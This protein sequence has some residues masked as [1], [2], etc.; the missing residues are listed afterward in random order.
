MIFDYDSIQDRATYDRPTLF[1][2]GIDYVLVNGQVVIDHGTHTG[3]KPGRIIYGPGYVA[4]PAQAT[5]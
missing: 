2:D 1:P 3:A 4:P 5:N